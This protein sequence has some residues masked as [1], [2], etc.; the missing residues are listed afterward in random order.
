MPTIKFLANKQ[1][2]FEPGQTFA[3]NYIQR[4][5]VLDYSPFGNEV[6]ISVMGVMQPKHA[7]IVSDVNN[8]LTY[9][10]V[11][12]PFFRYEV[13]TNP[14]DNTIVR[15]SVKTTYPKQVEY[16]YTL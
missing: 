16:R 5:V 15:V 9:Q 1:D 13:E 4:L 2:R 10:D 11:N 3:T 7:K 6:T 12:N 14:R 8:V